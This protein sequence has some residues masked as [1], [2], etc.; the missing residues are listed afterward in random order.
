MAGRNKRAVVA[1]LRQ[2]ELNIWLASEEFAELLSEAQWK[3]T[4]PQ[5]FADELC[6]HLGGDV[7]VRLADPWTVPYPCLGLVLRYR[8][9]GT[10]VRVIA[11][12]AMSRRMEAMRFCVECGQKLKRHPCT[13]PGR[14]VAR[15]VDEPASTLDYAEPVQWDDPEVE[16][17]LMGSVAIR[18]QQLHCPD[19]NAVV[20]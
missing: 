13:H 9:N 6:R 4:G 20:G 14:P 18:K 3:R 12:E 5:G 16:S 1:F 17:M 7:D 8:G 10:T 2:L 11:D 19:C 15:Y